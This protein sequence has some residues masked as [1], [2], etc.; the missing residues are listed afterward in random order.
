LSSVSSTSGRQDRL[1]IEDK[2]APTPAAPATPPAA[3]AADTGTQAPEAVEAAPRVRTAEDVRRAEDA[4]QEVRT[5]EASVRGR[6]DA[7]VAPSSVLTERLGDGEESCLERAVEGARPGKDEVVFMDDNRSAAAGNADGAGHALIRDRASG[8]V[9]DPND[10]AAPRNPAVWPYRSAEDWASKQGPAVDGRP[11]YTEAGAVRAER[12]QDVLSRPPEARAERIR[13][14]GDPAL[15]RVADRLYADGEPPAAAPALP[16]G[17]DPARAQRITDWVGTHGAE[18]D[19]D[20]AVAGALRGESELG[21]LTPAEQGY[22]TDRALDRW[23]PR[24]DRPWNDTTNYGAMQRLAMSA[25]QDPALGRVVAERYA[26]RAVETSRGAEVGPPGYTDRARAAALASGTTL[27]ARDP[28]ALR[29]VLDGMSAQDGAQL[30]QALALGGERLHDGGSFAFGGSPG[31][32]A[33]VFAAQRALEAVGHPPSEGAQG[34]IAAAFR[35]TPADVYAHYDG[36][37]GAMANAMASAWHPDDPAAAQR[38]GARFTGILQTEQGRDLLASGQVPA[39]ARADALNLL[40]ARPELDGAAL[41][42]HDGNGWTH[43]RIMTELARPRAESFAE[44]RGDDPRVLSGSDLD[45]TVGFAMGLPPAVPEGETDAQRDAREAAVARGEHSYYRDGPAAE[46][47][48]PVADAIRRIGGDDP[49]VTVLPVQYSSEETGPVELP[50]FRVQDRATGQ[51]RFVD[52]TGRTYD[53][54]EDWRENNKLPPGNMTYPEG[55]HLT[56]GEDGQVRLQSGNTPETVDTL[57]EHVT[58]VLDTAALVGGVIAGGAVILGSGGTAAPVVLGAAGLWGATRSG[59]RLLDRAQHGQSINPFTDG[60]ARSEWLNLGANALGVAAVGATAGALRLARAGSSLS[61][62]AATAASALSVS[63]AAADTLAMADAGYTLA[64]RWDELSGA[65]RAQLGLSMAFWGAGTAAR[66]RLS[67][68]DG[69]N[70]FDAGAMRRAILAE[71]PPGAVAADDFGAAYPQGDRTSVRR[72]LDDL[73]G[74][75]ALAQRRGVDMTQVDAEGL[76]SR[77]SQDPRVRGLDEWVSENRG[78]MQSPTQG[79]E[80]RLDHLNELRELERQLDG[81]PPGARISASETP[82]PGT[83]RNADLA[84]GDRLIE[85]K[86]VRDPLTQPLDVTGQLA[87]GVGKFDGATGP[88]PRE[89]VIY[90]SI[91]PELMAG[92]AGRGTVRQRYQDGQLETVRADNGQVVRSGPFMGEVERWLNNQMTRYGGRE[93]PGL[94]NTDRITVRLENGVD[95]VFVRDGNTWRL[96]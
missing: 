56:R 9:W 13:E 10:G 28:A 45:N 5:R 89:V 86:T 75:A 52:N 35:D 15:S 3:P 73:G 95:G 37:P 67:G 33:R 27:A 17:L 94:G 87:E 60:D 71:R 59:E 68:S 61:P 90:G 91:S 43:P 57:G 72:L 22:L 31:H 77:L 92:T 44:L 80:H 64:S 96:E 20:R 21:A 38:D 50:L 7:A 4:R 66:T 53:S 42:A 69:V 74:D 29:G 93:P 14:L 70:P 32:D 55:G 6:L 48:A 79:P 12:L 8:R 82:I 88:G 26:A 81:L 51:D 36:M 84:I 62:A 47:V 46:A 54:F 25:G 65:Q 39:Q 83:T 24:T 19:G 76:V 85:V 2:Q 49:R 34:F 11:P 16:E 58:R 63:A 40:R 18:Y 78:A 23:L 30:G 1:R 41:A